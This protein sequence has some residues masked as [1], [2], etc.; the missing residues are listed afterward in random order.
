MHFLM[1]THKIE[2]NANFIF[3]HLSNIAGELQHKTRVSHLHE[4]SFRIP[5]AL[6]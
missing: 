4:Y 5:F 1:F 2:K 3:T 6:Y